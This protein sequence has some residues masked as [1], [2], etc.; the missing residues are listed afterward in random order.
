MQVTKAMSSNPLPL[1]LALV[2]RQKIHIDY[3]ILQ[4]KC[5]LQNKY[6]TNLKFK[7]SSAPPLAF[8]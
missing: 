2:P 1:V 5:P 6:N 8:V 7:T 4:L 3:K